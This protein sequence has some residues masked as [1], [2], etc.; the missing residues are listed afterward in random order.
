MKGTDLTSKELI[1]SVLAL[2]FTPI[3]SF[4]FL[5]A[6]LL[7]YIMGGLRLIF[8][9]ANTFVLTCS[10]CVAEADS[11]SPIWTGLVGGSEG[12]RFTAEL[13]LLV[14]CFSQLHCAFQSYP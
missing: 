10:H 3:L 5:P 6:L 1:P 14:A 11:C 12:R 13:Q 2:Y 7:H 8:F 4:F 9:K